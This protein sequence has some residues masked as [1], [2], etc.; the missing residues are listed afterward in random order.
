MGIKRP[1]LVSLVVFI[2]ASTPSCMHTVVPPPVTMTP[3]PDA[4]TRTWR[5]P[6]DLPSLAIPPRRPGGA[7]DWLFPRRGADAWEPSVA[8]RD[9]NS[10]VL[11]HTAT[12]RGSVESIH[13]THLQRKDASGNAWLGIGYHFVIGNGNGMGDGEIQ[14]TFRWEQ[15]LQ[16]AHAGDYEHNQ[17]G[18][19]IAI[20]G[21]FDEREP[22]PA[23]LSAVKD[24]V[25]WLK[26]RFG[27]L[28]A[29]VI[30]HSEIKATACPG[31]YFPM[32]QVRLSI[33]R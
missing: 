2:A 7:G 10:I 8:A 29:D 31:R 11:H 1:L 17:R 6:N 5:A 25:G 23:Q 18:I 19:G 3:A 28:S 30:G 4:A 33:A 13:R 27:I 21:N 16:G 12:S 24:L 14:P 20:V 32:E 26:R 15:Q 9:W 22:T